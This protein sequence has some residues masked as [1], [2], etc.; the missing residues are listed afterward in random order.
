MLKLT[1]YALDAFVML[2]KYRKYYSCAQ[3]GTYSLLC[4]YQTC[5]SGWSLV[6]FSCRRLIPGSVTQPTA[7]ANC[8]AICGHLALV[9]SSGELAAVQ[10]FIKSEGLGSR[11]GVWVDG[12]DAAQEGV[13]LTSDGK[14]MTYIGFTRGQP[15]GGKNA[16]CMMLFEMEV[17][18][19][20]CNRVDY[21][22]ATLCEL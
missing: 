2:C 6:H 11:K 1:N 22:Y 14:V 13:W 9:S 20:N 16:N 15:N 17:W 21:S 19:E 18:D 5:L 8:Q 10:T 3:T 12:S 4:S 7:K